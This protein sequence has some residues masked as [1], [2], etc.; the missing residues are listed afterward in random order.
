MPSPADSSSSAAAV[1][2]SMRRRLAR[3][4]PPRRPATVNPTA[5]YLVPF[6]LVL[7]AG[8]ISRASSGRFE[9]WYALRLLAGGAA[10]A[11]YWPRLGGLDW[12]FSWRAGAAGLRSSC[13]G[14]WASH[15][16][17]PRKA[18]RPPWPRCPP[19]DR[20]LWI[21][22]RVAT[23]VLV[24]PLRRGVGL[25]RLSAAPAGGGGFRLSLLR[26]CRLDPGARHRRR[27]RNSRRAALARRHRGRDR[28]RYCC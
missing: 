19:P 3:T 18:C 6:L 5:A 12:R 13:C 24:L 7:A 8:M 15:F 11:V 16:L 26:G 28:V 10:L 1:A 20:A 14:S 9:T 22:G 27:V 25:S 4:A 2:G 23:A 17:V 21:A